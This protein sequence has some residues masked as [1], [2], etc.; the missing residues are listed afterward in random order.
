MLKERRTSFQV[1]FSSIPSTLTAASALILAIANARSDSFNILVVRGPSGM[2][3]SKQRPITMV[4]IP[5]KNHLSI[6]NGKQGNFFNPQ[7][8]KSRGMSV[9]RF[10]ALFGV[11]HLPPTFD[12]TKISNTQKPRGKETSNYISD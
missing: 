5:I 1:D 3:T 11:S 8:K 7:Q 12:R 10:I 9:I 6:C 4:T 2:I